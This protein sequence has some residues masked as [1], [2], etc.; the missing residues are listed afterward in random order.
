MN[1]AQHPIHIVMIDHVVLRARDM[2]RLVAFYTQVLGCRVERASARLVQ[3]RAG[4]SLIDVVDAGA[5]PP[6]THSERNVDHF[7]LQIEPW[8]EDVIVAHLR[9]HDVRVAEVV[10]RHGARGVGPSLYV[11]DPEGNT[12]E[13]KGPPTAS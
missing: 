7:C 9:H 5:S 10:Q 1:V 2:S 4:H 8:H 3:L 12:V 6:T 11:E 13:L